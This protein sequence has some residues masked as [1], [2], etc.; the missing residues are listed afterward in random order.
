MKAKQMCEICGHFKV[1]GF[2]DCGLICEECFNKEIMINAFN[3]GVEKSAQRVE[4]NKNHGVVE[5][6]KSVEAI[7]ITV[8]QLK[9]KRHLKNDK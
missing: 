3:D 9:M 7:A 8:R 5:S 2:T 6:Y 4:K 1:V